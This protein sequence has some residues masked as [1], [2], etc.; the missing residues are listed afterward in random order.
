MKYTMKAGVL[1][2]EDKPLARIKSALTGPEK[3][4]LSAKGELLA[5]S[6]IL[7]LETPP[8]R[9]GDVRFCRYTL[10]AK[11]GASLA[12][13]APDYAPEEDP[14]VTGWPFCRMPRVDRAKIWIGEREH[15][16][17]IQNSQNYLLQGPEGET[18]VM[19]RGLMGGWDIETGGSFGPELL[20]GTFVFCRYLEQENELFMV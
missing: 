10:T 9:R 8:E 5:R 3:R 18:R 12:S 1:Y 2:L 17:L 15:R 4:I 19:H 16:L 11:D 20:C 6:D 14:M 7:R 13:A